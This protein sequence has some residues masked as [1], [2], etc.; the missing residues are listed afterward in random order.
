MA[1]KIIG[2]R[3]DP[4]HAPENTMASF[5]KAIQAG[6]DGIELDVHMS[7][8]RTLVVHH[9]ET[10]MTPDGERPIAHL[11]W[12]QLKAIPG[13]AGERMPALTEV[14]RW[15]KRKGVWLNL[16]LKGGPGRY[17]GMEW[18]VH[19]LVKAHGLIN[20]V[21][22]SSFHAGMLQV[23]KRIDPGVS[24]GL[25]H[26]TDGFDPLG[27]ALRIGAQALHPFFTSVSPQLVKDCHIVG[28]KVYPWTV[29]DLHLAKGLIQMGVDG[30]I[31]NTPKKMVRLRDQ[32]QRSPGGKKDEAGR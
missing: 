28:L 32:L 5:K 2:H 19:R 24:V 15:A 3:G 17:P 27:T 8:D 21:L 20:Q 30:I 23:L 31:T 12:S 9:D 16:E 26:Y 10:V 14:L 18:A 22:I 25:L 7:R 6:V 4:E 11:T 29:D 13:G 1:V